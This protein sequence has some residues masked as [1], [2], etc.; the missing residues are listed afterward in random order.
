MEGLMLLDLSSALARD[1]R[2]AERR[3]LIETKLRGVVHTDL[4]PARAVVT[5]APDL[6]RN[7][8]V[9]R[10]RLVLRHARHLWALA[11]AYKLQYLGSPDGWP[12]Y[13]VIGR[14]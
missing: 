6:D 13:A 14:K 4:Q 2:A 12:T 1:M 5:L 10:G 11:K 9:N 3:V 7:Y 8:R